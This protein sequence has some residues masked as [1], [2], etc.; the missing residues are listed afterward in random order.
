MKRLIAGGVAIGLLAALLA[1]VDR[2]E[3]LANL[4]A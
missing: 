4:K 1:S 2:A 3:L